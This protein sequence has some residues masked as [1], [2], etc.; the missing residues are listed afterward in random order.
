MSRATKLVTGARLLDLRNAFVQLT[1]RRLPAVSDMRTAVTY[2]SIRDIADGYVEA[3]KKI[4][5]R[6]AEAGRLDEGSDERNQ[7]EQENA[8][9][10]A[11]LNAT[12]YEIP[13][14]RRRLT[15]DDLPS[16]F[17]TKDGS[18][19]ANAAGRAY[20]ASILQP[21]FFDLSSFTDP[22][23]KDEPSVDEGEEE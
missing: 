12:E 8:D 10:F 21:E 9:E 13:L 17:K 23:D 11:K 1:Q 18:G 22:D 14:P 4:Q 3:L 16:A 15:V 20:F 2:S 19:E 6:E 7:L 5:A